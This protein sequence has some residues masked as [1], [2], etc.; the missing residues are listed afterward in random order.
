MLY[1]MKERLRIWLHDWARQRWGPDVADR[2]PDRYEIRIPEPQ[3]GDL[4]LNVALVWAKAVGEPAS[5]LA[6]AIAEALRTWPEVADVRVAGPGFV[7]VRWDR[8]SWVRRWV[9]RL[10]QPVETAPRFRKIVIEHT[11]IN[12][13]KAAHVGHLRNAVLGDTLVRAW[14]FLG[15]NVEVQNY[16]DDTG[17]QVA[18]VVV[19]FYYMEGRKTVADLPSAPPPLDHYCW[20]LYT[21]VQHWYEEDPQRT[22]FREE[23]LHALERGEGPLAELGRWLSEAILR[24]HLATMERVGI[25]YDVLPKESDIVALRF[26]DHA[27]EL[28]KRRGAAVY[29]TEGPYRGCWILPL[30]GR[31]EWDA[32]E[33]PDKVLVRSNGTVTYVAKDIAYQLWKLGLLGQDFGYRLFH[34]YPDGHEVYTTTADPTQRPPG[35][36]FGGGERVYNVIDVRQSYLQKIVVE[37]LRRMGYEAA[38]EASIHFAYEMVALSARS[39][40]KMGIPVESDQK[41]IAFSGRRGI[42]VKADD[43]LDA[44][45][46]Q[47]RREVQARHPD[48]PSDEQARV[49]RE[50]ACGAVRYYL[51]RYG[52]QTVIAFDI[53]EA[54]QMEGETGPYLQYAWVRARNIFE[55]LGVWPDWVGYLRATRPADWPEDYW[56]S[57]EG[58]A[59]WQLF[60]QAQHLRDWVWKA[61]NAL[62]LNLITQYVYQLC[63]QF[64]R[65][66]LKYRIK[67]EPDPTLRWLRA[68][69]VGAVVHSLAQG[70]DVLGI[71]RPDMM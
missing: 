20:D 55:R 18:D 6:Q 19:G 10:G 69:A 34:V 17:V 2:L 43:L 12:P 36:S 35:R 24:A 50:I 63:Q 45:E 58:A 68:V 30:R 70:L 66:Y 59:T 52:R 65:Y 23:A 25:R 16:I 11:A 48:L 41:L 56:A 46:A 4:A 13:N 47:A 44:L 32:L 28:L 53:D 8:S 54:L 7:N 60:Y 29:A 64:H 9:E 3:W 15:E 61:V 31:P 5:A 1:E 49:A 27:F 71:P 62:E 21:R 67:Q 57:E 39:C 14:R 42:G 40:E 26:W 22:R 51:L 37:A 38:A 33:E